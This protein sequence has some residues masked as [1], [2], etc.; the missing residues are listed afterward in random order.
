MNRVMSVLVVCG[1]SGVCVV[2]GRAQGGVEMLVSGF[3][4]DRVERYDLGGPGAT[5]AHLGSLDLGAG[6]D[7]PLCQRVGPD[8]LLYV[9]DEGNDAIVRFNPSTGLKIDTFVAPGAGG[10]DGPTSLSWDAAGR[11]YVGS[12]N[13]DSVLRYRPDGSPDGVF[14]GAGSGGL[15]GP[16]NGATFG[17]DGRLYVPSYYSNRVL[18]YDG[19]TGA[20]LGAIGG[21]I[22]H[23]RVI[24]FKDQYML[25]TSETS[26]SVRRYL[27]STGQFVDHFVAQGAGGLNN[28]T[29]MAFGPDGHL[30]V[31]SSTTHSV[32]KFDGS[33]GA[34]L[35]V[36]V[37]PGLGGLSGPV[38][39]SF[40]PGPG[41]GAAGLALAAWG[42]SRRRRAR[43]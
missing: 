25:V 37:S 19:Q 11:L 8:G 32:L 10:L 1:V 30:Y 2:G 20:F 9:A 14:V 38:F 40:V 24:L 26:S 36:A 3:F 33:T 27:L 42:C 15:N 23:P 7:G 43:W 18:R 31:A 16:D 41:G 4:S 21:N 22:S 6:L 13:T 35:G 12:F 29:G 34:Y 39:I 28:P 17:P 5:G